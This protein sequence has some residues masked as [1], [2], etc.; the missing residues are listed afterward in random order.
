MQCDII[1]KTWTS[2]EETEYL[3]ICLTINILLDY[4]KYR[5]VKQKTCDYIVVTILPPVK[6]LAQLCTYMH[7]C[8]HIHIY[9]LNNTTK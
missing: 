5:N 7:V 3:Y 9:R 6:Q 4:K 8:M 1:T 2:K